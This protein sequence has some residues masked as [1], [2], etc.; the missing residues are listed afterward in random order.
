MGAALVMAKGTSGVGSAG[1][2][3]KATVAA[4]EALGP[5]VYGEAGGM[6]KRPPHDEAWHGID[7]P[8]RKGKR[9]PVESERMQGAPTS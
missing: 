4:S 5:R 6:C 9:V 8:P 7:A 1:G 3:D 2:A